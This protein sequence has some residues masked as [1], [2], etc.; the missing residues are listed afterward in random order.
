MRE[1]R[2][3]RKGCGPDVGEEVRA[4]L[5]LASAQ[6]HPGSSLPWLPRHYRRPWRAGWCDGR[7]TG[8]EDRSCGLSPSLPLANPGVSSE[9][10]RFPAWCFFLQRAGKLDSL[11]GHPR[12]WELWASSCDWQ[13]QG[14]GAGEN[15]DPCRATCFPGF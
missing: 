10:H 13:S 2:K 5:Q 12:P 8:L 6:S 11:R 9:P 1:G 15:H 3:D 4:L 7:G 14:P